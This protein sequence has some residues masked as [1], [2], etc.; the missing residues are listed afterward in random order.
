MKLLFDQ[1]LSPHL[2]TML[3]DMFPGTEHVQ[4]VGLDRSLDVSLW[5]FARDKGFLIVTKDADF[6]DRSAVAGHPPKVIWIRLG[7]CTTSDIES[8]IRRNY[9]R[10]A[11]FADDEDFGVLALFG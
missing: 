1:N 3:A 7:N 11:A 2:A 4:T 10:V 9:E 8:A 5:D 6:S